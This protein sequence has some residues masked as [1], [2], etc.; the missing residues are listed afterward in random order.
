MTSNLQKEQFSIAYVHALASAAGVKI[1]KGAVDD[2]SVDVGLERTGGAA[3]KL[4]LQ[5]NCTA[6]PLPSAGDIPFALSRK[7]YDDLRR[8]TVAPRWL[9]VLFVPTECRD[10]VSLEPAS[11]TILKHTA[12]WMSLANHPDTTNDAS[13]TVYL[14]RDNVLRPESIVDKLNEVQANFRPA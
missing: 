1:S 13:V 12:W 14:P 7:N 2:D 4:D 3:P 6:D 8:R 5:L 11:M 9:V 10:W